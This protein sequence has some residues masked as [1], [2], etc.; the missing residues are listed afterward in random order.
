MR[1]GL[2]ERSTIESED[3][4]DIIG[5]PV[6]KVEDSDLGMMDLEQDMNLAMTEVF[7][8]TTLHSWKT[9]LK[10]GGEEVNGWKTTN[11]V[12]SLGLSLLRTIYWGHSQTFAYG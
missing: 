8:C 11:P 2:K 7:R 9:S 1:L 10:N 12:L 6:W 3:M 4:E 5:D